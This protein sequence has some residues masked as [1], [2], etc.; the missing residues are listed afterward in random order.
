M[1]GQGRKNVKYPKGFI[2]AVNQ[3]LD[4]GDIPDVVAVK[5]LKKYGRKNGD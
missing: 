5:M 1:Y 4:N 3:L 2:T